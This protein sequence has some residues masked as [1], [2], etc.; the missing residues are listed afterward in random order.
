MK[1]LLER[2]DVD[3]DKPNNWGQTPLWQAAQGGH[4]GMVK[5]LLERDDV[6]PDKLDIFGQTPLSCATLYGY[7]GV[8]ALL[9]PEPATPSPAEDALPSLPPSNTDELCTISRRTAAT[10]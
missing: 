7:A 3:P 5:I 2:D 6:D 9:Q 8:V 4:E 10:P 1:I